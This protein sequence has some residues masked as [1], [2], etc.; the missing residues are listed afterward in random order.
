LA[1]QENR[2][3]RRPENCS[4]CENLLLKPYL[5]LEN[6]ERRGH[7]HTACYATY[8][9]C[10]HLSHQ[11]LLPVSKAS[12]F[13]NIRAAKTT[14]FFWQLFPAIRKLFFSA[15]MRMLL[16][17]NLIRQ[18]NSAAWESTTVWA[19]RLLSQESTNAQNALKS[20]DWFNSD[21]IIDWVA[22]YAFDFLIDWLTIRR[23][24]R[25]RVCAVCGKSR[26]K[27]DDGWL[28]HRY[29]LIKYLLWLNSWN[30]ENVLIRMRVREAQH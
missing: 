3:W 28:N 26:T 13:F 12:V 1:K 6:L 21:W 25:L 24:R 30:Y 15:A 8:Y 9:L 22:D 18:L 10:I 4:S 7:S 19:L 2:N 14:F 29:I 20:S 5:D 23:W 27:L 16:Y 17:K 11:K